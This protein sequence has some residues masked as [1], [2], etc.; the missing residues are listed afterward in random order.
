MF[1]RFDQEARGVVSRAHDEAAELGHG[2]VGTEH[3]LLALLGVAEG[4]VAQVL[5]PAGITAA[6][7]RAEVQSEVGGPVGPGDAAALR[8]IGIDLDAVRA[9]IEE[10]FGPGALDR[11]RARPEGRRSR[12]R[13]RCRVWPPAGPPGARP[14]T[15]RSK[16]VLELAL[17]HSLRLGHDHIGPEHVLLGLLTEGGGLAAELLVRRGV[18]LDELRRRVLAALGQVA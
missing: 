14:L 16:K 3:L 4:V 17:R 6:E 7:L 18:R 8:A 2:Y 11:A 12:R 15:P 10:A 1:E 5:A 13:R 9:T